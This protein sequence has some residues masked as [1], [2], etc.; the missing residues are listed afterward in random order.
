MK[1]RARNTDKQIQKALYNKGGIEAC[2]RR[3]V[4]VFVCMLCMTWRAR[5][6]ASP[7][8]NYYTDDTPA[9]PRPA[10]LC[11]ALPRCEPG[12]ISNCSCEQ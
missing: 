7:T 5:E 9:L 1:V 6:Y 12:T 3:T 2:G 4:R 10:P 8:F 11:P